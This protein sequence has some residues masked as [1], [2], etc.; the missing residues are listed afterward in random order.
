[1]TS[2]ASFF[3]CSSSPPA[4]DGPCV[5]RSEHPGCHPPS[6]RGFL[7]A[8]TGLRRNLSLK[9][10]SSAR[11]CFSR[12]QERRCHPRKAK[13][14]P[15]DCGWWEGRRDAALPCGDSL[16]PGTVE[17]PCAS[18]QRQGCSCRRARG[19]VTCPPEEGG[20]RTQPAHLGLGAAIQRAQPGC[21]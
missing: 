15:P 16:L 11:G 7:A 18:L 8:V 9:G 2:L 10:R 21:P 12:D 6:Q 5:L 20:L 1:V 17:H 13:K 19:S 4:L 3:P 14:K